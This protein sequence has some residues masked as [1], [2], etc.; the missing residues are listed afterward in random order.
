MAT[1]DVR[2]G[3]PSRGLT[4]RA[5]LVGL[6]GTAVL[7]LVTPYSDLYLRTT[8]IAACHLPIGAFLLFIILAGL[9]NV[10]LKAIAR[11]LG[12]SHREVLVSYCI[13]LA[14][15]GIPAFG[16]TEYVIPTL[17]GAFYYQTPENGW[18][19]SFFKHIPQ[20]FVPVDLRHY[21]ISHPSGSWVYALYAHL[22]QSWHPA[23][24]EL[25]RTF[26]EGLAQGPAESWLATLRAMPYQAWIVPLCAWTLMA[27]VLFFIYLCIS[28]I[29]RRQWVERERLTFPLVQVP[30]EISG[31]EPTGLLPPFFRQRLMWVGF[32]VPM[33]L[34]SINSIHHYFPSSPEIPLNWP[35]EPFF[36]THP[37]NQIG[38]LQ[39]WTH[40]SVIG[41][42]FLLPLELSIS[43]WLFFFLYKAEGIFIAWLGYD[44]I[45]VPNYPVPSYAAMQMLGSFLFLGGGMAYAARDHLSRVWRAA[46]RRAPDDPTEPLPYRVAVWGLIGGILALSLFWQA[47]GLPLPL[48]IVVCVLFLITAILLTR[49][50]S[51]GGL[52]FI[53]APF[54]P[55]DMMAVFVGTTPLGPRNLTVLAYLERG[56]S[57]FDLRGFLMP[58]MMDIWKISDSSGLNKR[59]LVPALLAGVLIATITSYVSLLVIC[60]R[61]GAV[62]LEPWFAIWSP[63]QPFQVLKSYLE[64]PVEPNAANIELIG[65]GGFVTWI[66]I[67]MRMRYPWW[68]L[69]PIGYAMGP[70][71]PMIQLWFSIMVGSIMKGLILRFGGM[72]LYRK[73]RPL[74]LGLVLGEFTVAGMWIVID[75]ITGMRGHRFFLF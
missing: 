2:R 75:T 19:A 60:Y 33:V 72:S 74:F 55:T 15:A 11:P 16:L 50:V 14:G 38:I 27:Y 62:T 4:P 59:R 52:L 68:P 12:L 7:G 65:A 18:V 17:T 43:L 42:S 69:H 57:I 31:Q 73:S 5:I 41:F 67:V 46:I 45:N 61:Y 21:G 28:V 64:S 9:A 49:F 25:A 56:L 54:R 63:Q 34:Y 24:P 35:L 29:L 6:A 23:A 48:G 53:Q 20:W 39:A 66:L 58:F 40:F 47:A 71:W 3:P 36:R 51:E 70:S 1:P 8:W 30:L 37:W 26:N 13:M 10:A 44:I 32:A 22:P